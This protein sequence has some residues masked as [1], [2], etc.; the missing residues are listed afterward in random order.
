MA[1]TNSENE[2]LAFLVM[3][4]A[5]LAGAACALLLKWVIS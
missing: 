2:R 5:F 4:G 3:M 1:R